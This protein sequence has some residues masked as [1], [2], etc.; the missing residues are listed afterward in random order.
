MGSYA[1]LG[2]LGVMIWSMLPAFIAAGK[3][4]NGFAY[5]FLS[6]IISP[7]WG[8][9]V[10]ACLPN[11]K[12][13]RYKCWKCG[14]E[15]PF[16]NDGPCTNCGSTL[17]VW[18]YPDERIYKCRKCGTEG[19]FPNDG[20]CPK[21]GSTKRFWYDAPMMNI[22]ESTDTWPK[23]QEK[24][25]KCGKCGTDG[26]FE[27]DPQKSACPKCGCVLKEWYT[28]KLSSQNNEISLEK[29]KAPCSPKHNAKLQIVKCAFCGYEG[30]FDENDACPKC[31][32]VIK[33][34]SLS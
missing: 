32:C 22:V 11:L 27:G 3:G 4:R 34:S 18:Y 2:A 1:A 29:E 8:T 6:W 23:D 14:T 13:R 10:V 20:P 28:A 5:Y 15:G 9:I 33:N 12:K 21:C 19:P 25:Y 24:R 26:P 31:G 7:L 30:S 16:P 17:R